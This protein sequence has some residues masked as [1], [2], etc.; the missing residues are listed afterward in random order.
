MNEV[1]ECGYNALGFPITYRRI[2]FRNRQLIEFVIE[3]QSINTRRWML[4]SISFALI[5]YVIN[6]NQLVTN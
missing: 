4:L 3:K 2:Y 6:L 5:F 1:V